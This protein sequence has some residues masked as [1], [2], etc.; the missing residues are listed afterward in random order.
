M[1][2]RESFGTEGKAPFVGADFTDE[3]FQEVVRILLSRRAFDLGSYKDRCIKRRIASRVRAKG[4]RSSANYVELLDADNDEIDAL[5][6]VLTI[7]VSH[8]FRNPST[9]RV[10]EE[11]IFPELLAAA[12]QTGRKQLRIWSVGCSSGEEPYSLALLLH[13]MVTD[14]VE[15]SI[16]GTD[17]SRPILKKAESGEYDAQRLAEVP[18]IVRERYFERVESTRFQLTEEIRQRVEFRSHD[19]LK[20]SDYPAADLILCRNV[21]IYFSREEQAKILDRFARAL[22]PD[23]FLVLGRAETLV[24]SARHIFRSEYPV[25]RIYR[26]IENEFGPERF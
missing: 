26:C 7:H 11:K 22:G 9:Y 25:E 5:L 13:E 21:M 2:D 3:D 24:G 8:F 15:V 12:R 1:T 20:N 4:L 23:R 14:D 6:A 16:L 18:D 17:I 19:V 10:L